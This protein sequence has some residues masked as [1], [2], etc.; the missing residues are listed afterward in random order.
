MR[1]YCR[2]SDAPHSQD[3][4]TPLLS[5]SR[6]RSGH[7][8]LAPS[9]TALMAFEDT[10]WPR[11]TT[12]QGLGPGKD[13]GTDANATCS[14]YVK[15]GTSA[16]PGMISEDRVMRRESGNWYRDSPGTDTCWMVAATLPSPP[17]PPT[18][19]SYGVLVVIVSWYTYPVPAMLARSVYSSTENDASS[20]VV[21]VVCLPPATITSITKSFAVLITEAVVT[22][23]VT[24][25]KGLWPPAG[26]TMS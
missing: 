12:V 16:V 3:T 18:N 15:L 14:S 13:R 19:P 8:W 5:N 6:A 17:G 7:G 20:I 22:S 9:S 4:Y 2:A 10:P 11:A 25:D 1:R 26:T 23:A 24:D 21:A